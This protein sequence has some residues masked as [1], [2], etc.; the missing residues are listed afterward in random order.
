LK[1]RIGKRTIGIPV[2]IGKD[3]RSVTTFATDVDV[4]SDGDEQHAT[5]AKCCEHA[6]ILALDVVEP[7][8]KKAKSALNLT[9][10]EIE[11][12][13]WGSHG[14]TDQETADR[15]KLSRWTVVSHVQSAKSKLRVSNKAAAIARAVELKLFFDFD[16]KLQLRTD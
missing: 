5:L 10:R 1:H 16:Q 7:F 9:N 11:V 13:Y 12:L 6:H 4:G 3:I 15:M 2:H 14:K 8:M